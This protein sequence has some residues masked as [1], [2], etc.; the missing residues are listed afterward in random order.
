MIF[1]KCKVSIWLAYLSLLYILASGYYLIVTQYYGTPLKDELKKYPEL[2]KIKLMSARKR[3]FTFYFG[4][5]LAAIICFYFKPFNNCM[6]G[7][8]TPT[9]TT[10]VLPTDVSAPLDMSTMPDVRSTIPVSST[11]SD[12]DVPESD[13][14]KSL[15]IGSENPI[16]YA[17]NLNLSDLQK[18][19][20]Y[21]SYY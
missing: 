11:M 3:K 21:R 17:R 12:I 9:T 13:L 7:C 14:L 20:Y 5:I 1:D 15:D 10:T 18:G 16:D 19:G 8:T 2:M 6:S 4:L